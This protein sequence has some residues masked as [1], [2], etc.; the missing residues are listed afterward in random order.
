MR[1]IPQT[2]S[3]SALSSEIQACSSSDTGN[4]FVSCT[5]MLSPTC[6]LQPSPCPREGVVLWSDDVGAWSCRHHLLLCSAASS[7]SWALLCTLDHH[8]I[9]NLEGPG[10]PRHLHGLPSTWPSYQSRTKSCHFST[11]DTS[12]RLLG[13]CHGSGCHRLS[14]AALTASLSS[15]LHTVA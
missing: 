12:A 1:V 6:R 11:C 3:I 15:I 13:H 10:N 9:L 5:M 14:P 4:I 2:V 7:S 8:H